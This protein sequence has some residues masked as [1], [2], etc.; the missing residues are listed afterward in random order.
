M[1]AVFGR[2]RGR[3]GEDCCVR[4]VGGLLGDFESVFPT[5]RLLPS[6]PQGSRAPTFAALLTSIFIFISFFGIIVA[7]VFLPNWMIEYYN[8]RTHVHILWAV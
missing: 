4:R 5:S 1:F 2:R 3:G 8:A 6:H 7:L